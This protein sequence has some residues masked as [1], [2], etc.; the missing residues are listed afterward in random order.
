MNVLVMD[1]EGTDG[2]ERG[3]DQVRSRY[4]YSLFV[5]VLP[6]IYVGLRAKVGSLLPCLLGG[7]HC[8]H[9]GT[10][11]WPVSGCEYGTA[12]DGV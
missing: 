5:V 9:V 11:S 4:Y 3:E 12:Q 7:T 2:R 10:P 1:V 8:Q 6:K